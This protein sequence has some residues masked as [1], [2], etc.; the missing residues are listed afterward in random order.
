MQGLIAVESHGQVCMSGTLSDFAGIGVDAA[1]QV[2]GQ[3]K[4]TAFVQ[5]VH[6]PAGGK[7]GGPQCAMESGAVCKNR[8]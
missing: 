5:M 7:A 4:S 1:G 8:Q 2:Y 6:Q 3:N